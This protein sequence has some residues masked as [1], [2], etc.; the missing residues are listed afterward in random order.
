MAQSIGAHVGPRIAEVIR[1][2][3]EHYDAIMLVRNAEASADPPGAPAAIVPEPDE[4]C[5]AVAG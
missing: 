1:S 5:P 4:L 2:I 3:V